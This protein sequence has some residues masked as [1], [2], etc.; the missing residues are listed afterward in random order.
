M[1]TDDKPNYRASAKML[2]YTQRFSQDAIP[3]KPEDLTSL[4]LLELT[5]QGA[6]QEL[7][8]WQQGLLQTI[9]YQP[10]GSKHLEEYRAAMEP[11]PELLKAW[12]G[13]PKTVFGDLV[14][15]NILLILSELPERAPD[16]CS[17]Y[18]AAC[19]NTLMS[20]ANPPHGDEP[21]HVR[22]TYG[23]LHSARLTCQAI[24]LDLDA[25]ISSQGD[26]HGQ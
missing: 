19:F 3:V 16:S 11:I 25:S 22:Q 23:Y 24:M 17:Y 10:L 20:L 1:T 8:P 12:P 4:P 15:R 9:K 5:E 14:H 13:E 7:K 21:A 2:S 26:D 18:A 6:L